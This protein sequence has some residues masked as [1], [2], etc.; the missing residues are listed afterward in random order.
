VTLL[1]VSLT[2]Q[3][4]TVRSVSAKDIVTGCAAEGVGESSASLW[5]I[6]SR[7]LR[8]GT[9][10]RH[11]TAHCG[12]L[13]TACVW[14]LRHTAGTLH[15][16]VRMSVNYMFGIWFLCVFTHFNTTVL[17]YR[18]WFRRI[19]TKPRGWGVG[20]PHCLPTGQIYLIIKIQSVPRSKHIP[21]QL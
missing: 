17:M 3:L 7:F 13:A 20:L 4:F 16:R 8:N 1:V 14:Q 6:R 11:N 19:G 2:A 15:G 21:F 5:R 9:M 12:L 18:D 10:F